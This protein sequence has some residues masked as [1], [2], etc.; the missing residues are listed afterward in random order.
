MKRPDG[1]DRKSEPSPGARPARV[2][3]STGRA[4]GRSTEPETDRATDPADDRE[5][6]RGGDRRA[7]A[8][9]ES[10]R[11]EAR[12][13]SVDDGL[14]EARKAAR[15]S[16][17]ERRRFERREVRRFTR[18]TRRRRIGWL[19]AGFVAAALVGLVAVAVFS[20]LLALEEVR[21]EGTSRLD[22]AEIVD[23]V[24]GQVDTPLALVDFDRI[25]TELGRFPLI[26]SFVTESIPPDTLVIHVVERQPI[27][28][29][30]SG[31][32]FELVDPAGVVIDEVPERVAGVPLI[33]IAGGSADSVAFAAAVEVLLALPESVGS[34]L[35]SITA[36]SRD[37]VSIVL[38]GDGARIIWGSADDSDYKARVLAPILALDLPS[39]TEYNVSAPGQVTYR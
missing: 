24:D 22:A 34:Q 16:A 9:S 32:R 19:T 39:V 33:D 37:D 2:R 29:L 14:R 28:V 12:R 31:S 7:S 18:R 8:S 35:E 23:A 6:A 36:S 26:R 17:R 4:T 3:P 25:S 30:A 13:D 15:R 27:G 1:F 20:P 38:A 5:P 10:I 21:V 11:G